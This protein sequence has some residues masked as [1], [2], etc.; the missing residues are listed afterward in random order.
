M[1]NDG[2]PLAITEPVATSAPGDA[3]D[4]LGFV[5]GLGYGLACVVPFWGAVIAAA[6]LAL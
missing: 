2:D 3:D 1:D 4:A 6:W 5:R